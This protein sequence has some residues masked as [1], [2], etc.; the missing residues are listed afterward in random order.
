MTRYRALVVED[1]EATREML[2]AILVEDGY[3][4]HTEPTIQ[5]GLVAAARLKPDLIILDRV[6]PDGD[7]LQLCLKFR[8]DSLLRGT[9]VL[10]LTAKTDVS[11]KILGLRMGA[12]DYLAKPFNTDEFRARVAAVM[13]RKTDATLVEPQTVSVGPIMMNMRSRVVTVRNRVIGLTNKEFDL[14]RVLIT[15]PDKVLTRDFLLEAV[16]GIYV[17]VVSTKMIDV[18]VMNLRRKMGPSSANIVAVRSFGYKFQPF[19]R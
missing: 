17:E 15:N 7:G 19:R 13:R 2:K 9:P 16:W 1:D 10:M 8:E 4:T 5:G 14:L 18:T 12:D 6:L 3:A 11:D